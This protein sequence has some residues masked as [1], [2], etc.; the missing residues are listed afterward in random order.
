MKAN[1][2]KV[3]DL[4][5]ALEEKYKYRTLPK[6]LREETLDFYKANLNGFEDTEKRCLINGT[7]IA[8]KYERICTGHYGSYVEFKP[9]DIIIPYE[10]AIGQSWRLNKRYLEERKLSIKYEWYTILGC[11]L[12]FQLNTVKYADYKPGFIYISVLDFD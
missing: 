6:K 5:T 3:R 8:E 9:E 4:I 12:Y 11:K 2:Q 1:N 7:L 10:V